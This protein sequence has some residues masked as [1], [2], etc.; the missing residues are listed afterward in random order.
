MMTSKERMMM[1]IAHQEP[2]QVPVGEWEYGKE[3][4]DAVL[5]HETFFA[6]TLRR[7]QALWAGRRDEVIRDWQQGLVELVR[8]LNW[9]A[10]LV[11][12]VIGRATPIPAPKPAGENRWR[13]EQGNLLVYS[14]ETERVMIVERGERTTPSRSAS[15]PPSPVPTDSELDVVRHVV[16]ELGRTHF[17]FSA[18]LLGHP[19]L[20]YGDAT[21]GG[22][23]MDWVDLYEAPDAF[24][25]RHLR[26]AKGP[27]FRLGVATARREGMDGIAFGWDYGTNTGP[28]MSSD[29]FRAYV[30]PVVEAYVRVVH[31][32][33]LIFLHHACGNNQGLMEMLVEAGVDVYQSIQP[34]MDIIAMKRRYG[35][36]ITLWGGVSSGDLITGRPDQIAA[37]AA[38]YLAEC[39]PGGGY[40]FGSSHSVM[41]GSRVENYM[42]MLA[43][44]SRHGRYG[45]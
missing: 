14:P 37:A 30:L 19:E 12:L 24:L 43:A 42:A 18:P 8:T 16:R 29:I 39:K 10:V 32:A 41:P 28:F 5:G 15:P 26:A 22:Q 21:S 17:V 23:I 9:D 35:S 27:D 36:R 1:A 20:R 11:H 25:E 38:R 13:D 40:I 7:I 34:E 45:A 2:D 31:D 3:L 6:P 33:G 4:I 44:H